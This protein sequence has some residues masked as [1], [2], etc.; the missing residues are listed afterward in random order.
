M[1]KNLSGFTL[2]ELSIVLVIIGLLVGGIIEGSELIQQAKMKSAISEL[3]SLTTSLKTFELKYDCVAGDCA[4]ASTF[5]SGA[6]NGGGDGLVALWD[7]SDD[8]EVWN[9]FTHL[10]SAKLIAGS[11]TGVAGS[12]GSRHAVPGE[13]VMKS[14]AFA[15]AGFTYVNWGGYT[16]TGTFASSWIAPRQNV[17]LFGQSLGNTYET[18]QQMMTP[19]QA[20]SF[21]LKIDDG[22]PGT[23][24]MMTSRPVIYGACATSSVAT[25][26]TYV[27]TDDSNIYCNVMI[28]P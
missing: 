25:T 3:R 17:I 8:T 28:V 11:Y 15:K 1:K 10:S 26:A 21:D 18:I 16:D 7:G 6:T 24:K 23:G 12:A 13:N 27:S 14:K 19:A 22:K 4:N 2:V 5:F 20:Y 9:V